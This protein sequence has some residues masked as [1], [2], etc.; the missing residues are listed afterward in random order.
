MKRKHFSKERIIG[1]LKEAEAGAEAGG[2]A[3]ELCR[4]QGMSSA[5][6][7]AWKSKYAARRYPRSGCRRLRAH[8]RRFEEFGRYWRQR[9]FYNGLRRARTLM[10]L[11]A[12]EEAYQAQFWKGEPILTVDLE[13]LRI[14]HIM[15]RSWQEHWP[16]VDG[17]TP[18]Q[19]TWALHGIG[20]LTLI[21]QK[22]NPSLANGPWKGDADACKERPA[23][24]AQQAGNEPLA[25]GA[26][27][28]RDGRSHCP[29]GRRVV[30]GA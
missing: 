12:L 3:T 15:P 26:A 11:K 24:A 19:R 4:K 8:R 1:I 16:I 2:V 7:L 27:R 6:Y 21:S 18:E 17:I 14:E 29:A 5:T 10:V 28:R 30:S 9:N 20:N 13:A 25:A 22:P 23:E